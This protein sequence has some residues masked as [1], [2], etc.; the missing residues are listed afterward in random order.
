MV[1]QSS[2]NIEKI[3]QKIN[4]HTTVQYAMNTLVKMENGHRIFSGLL[5]LQYW[6][7]TLAYSEVGTGTGFHFQFHF[8]ALKWIT[9]K[10]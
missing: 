5:I 1:I 8:Q 7:E 2:V 9:Y 4:L 6:Q 3:P 10:S